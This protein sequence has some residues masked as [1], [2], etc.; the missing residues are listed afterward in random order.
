MTMMLKVGDVVQA[1]ERRRKLLGGK[2]AWHLAQTE[3]G[4]EKLARDRLRDAGYEAYFPMMR[5]LKPVPRKQLSRKQRLH[6]ATVKRPHLSALFPGYLMVR[7]DQACGGWHE[8]FDFAHVRGLV[9]TNG[10][11][12]PI[13]DSVV[14]NLRGKE[15]DGAVPGDTLAA[16]L[17]VGDQV[18]IKCGPFSSFVGVVDRLPAAKLEELD[19]SIR[20]HLL[21]HLFGAASSVELGLGDV[22]K[23]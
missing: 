9:V 12:Q 21:I 23:I 19:E 4:R 10:L 11:I 13:S 15:V 2:P 20:I 17:Q 14:E 8:M 22:E 7:F 16:I 5:V 1:A 18:R 3:S 6:G